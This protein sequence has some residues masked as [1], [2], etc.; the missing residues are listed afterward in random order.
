MSCSKGCCVE[1]KGKYE[2]AFAPLDDFAKTVENFTE[3]INAKM[4]KMLEG[5]QRIENSLY[6]CLKAVEERPADPVDKTTEVIVKVSE[7]E[8][9]KAKEYSGETVAVCEMCIKKV[10]KELYVAH[11]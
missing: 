7:E 6:E 2:E 4:L 8:Y 10:E 9:K 5:I 11:N 3:E 1:K